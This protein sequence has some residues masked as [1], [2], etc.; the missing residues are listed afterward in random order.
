MNAD[1]LLSHYERIADAPDAIDRLRR[2]IL[3]LAMGGKLSPNS[4]WPANPTKLGAIATLQNGYAFK[5]EWFSKSGTCLLRNKNVGH[6]VINWD[7]QVR[8][9]N[10][11]VSEYERFQLYEGDIVL[12]LDRP[13]ISTGI[14]VARVTAR[15]LPSLLLQRVARFVLS[16][17]L[18][19][20]YLFLWINSPH[21]TDQI[22][23]GRSNGVPHISSKQVESAVI[24]LPPVSEQLRI[25]AKVDELMALC[26]R[27]EAERAER[28]AVRDRLTVVSLGRL[29]EP[30]VD[31]ETFQDDARF[32][33]AALPALTARQVQIKTFRRT[34]LDLAVQGKLVPQDPTDEP[35]SELMERIAS[36]KVALNRRERRGV[37]TRGVADI[38]GSGSVPVGWTI[39]PLKELVTVLNGRAYK[40]HELLD[41]GIPVLRVGNLFTSNK[42][43]Y[44]DLNL[45]EDKY[46]EFGDLI[47][48]WSASF[49]PFIWDGGKVIY[50]YHIWKLSLHSEADLH[51]RY[52]YAFL[53]QKTGDIKASGHG[54]S[55][56]HMTK[57]K[58]E[59]LPVPVPPLAEQK[60]IVAKVDELMALGEQLEASLN[61][62]AETR[63][64]LLDALIADALA[65]PHKAETVVDRE[66]ALV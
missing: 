21:F 28:E 42:W 27:L 48:A 20:D 8:L 10:S 13:F 40:Q 30:D 56:T 61:D 57:K 38:E 1:R 3:N 54:V 49:G 59:L 43:F 22:N 2:F 50:H 17:T 64:R 44:S 34:I 66:E 46:I 41:A 29:G 55:M 25:V 37:A 63:S 9:P 32:V 58:M 7:E 62:N 60:R 11:R 5:S 6:G 16:P 53:L 12:S 36:Q 4:A 45:G 24:Y 15:D 31:P 33:L 39:V 52:L 14:K 35:A 26:D 23:P 47:Y 18:H 51:K 19:P 65:Q